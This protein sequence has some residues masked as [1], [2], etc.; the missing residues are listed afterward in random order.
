MLRTHQTQSAGSTTQILPEIRMSATPPKTSAIRPS[1]APVRPSPKPK[2]CTLCTPPVLRLIGRR[3]TTAPRIDGA[4][5]FFVLTKI[6][7]AGGSTLGGNTSCPRSFP[8]KQFTRCR[9]HSSLWAKP[10]AVMG[11]LRRTGSG[12]SVASDSGAS[13]SVPSSS[14]VVAA[15]RSRPAI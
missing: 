1:P 12:L 7:P 9:G 13:G 4:R 3:P 2:V 5:F 10:A 6:D 8:E 11:Q 14:Y 15:A